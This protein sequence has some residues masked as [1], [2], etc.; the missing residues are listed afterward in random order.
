MRNLL[1]LRDLLLNLAPAIGISDQH[2]TRIQATV[3]EDNAGALSLAKLEP[4][5][6]T[7]RSKHYAV[8]LHWFRSKL[9]PEGTN[10]ISVVKIA[11]DL[12]RADILTKGLTKVKFKAIRKLLCGW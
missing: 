5:R 8:K 6:S 12:Q 2:S 4:G 1:S 7:P 9:D 3:H 11:T 10:P